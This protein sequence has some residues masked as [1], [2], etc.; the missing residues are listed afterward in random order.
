MIRILAVGRLKANWAQEACAEYEKR[1][2][3]FARIEVVEL[4][5]EDPAREAR[6]MLSR[7]GPSEHLVACDPRGE[8][9]SSEQF[10]ELLG[11]HGSLSFAIGGP[12]GL[13]EEVGARA[14]SSWAFGRI[15]LPHELVRVVLLEQIYRGLSI[16]AGHPYHR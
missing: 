15:T 14:R 7:L 4:A 6:S 13:G 5:D 1:A 2:R 11:H 8:L 12:E 10:A 3:R 16:R 9:G